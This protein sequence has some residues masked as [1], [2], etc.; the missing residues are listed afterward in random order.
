[1]TSKAARSRGRPE[2]PPDEVA[3]QQEL[4]L[5][6]L[7]LGKPELEINAVEGMVCLDTRWRWLADKEFSARRLE[8]QRQGVEFKL[9]DAEN[10]LQETY[11]K[12]VDDPQASRGRSAV[13]AQRRPIPPAAA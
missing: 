10:K 6:L 3:R 9:I 12:A 1:M 11:D 8:A 4:Y 13:F 5:S 2:I 7:Q